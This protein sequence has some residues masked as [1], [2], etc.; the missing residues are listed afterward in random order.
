MSYISD[1]EHQARL[2]RLSEKCREIDNTDPETPSAAAGESMQKEYEAAREVGYA[3]RLLVQATLPHSKPGPGV[4][5]FERC[6]GLVTLKITADSAYGLP[7]GTYPRLILAWITSEAVRRKSAELELGDSLRQFMVK[8]GLECSGGDQGTAPRLREHMRRLFTS[9]VSATVR[10]D[11]EWHNLGFRPVERISMFWDPKRP[12]QTTIWRSCIRLNHTFYEEITRQPV[13]VDMRALQGLGLGKN[14]SPMALD[15][16][17]WLTHRFSYLKER[18][19]VPW[20]ALQLQFGG[21]YGRLRNFRAKFLKH[22]KTVLE[23]YP[24][25]D[26]EPTPRGLLLTPSKTHVPMR[27]IRGGSK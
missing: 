16:Y 10:R 3:S 2:L 15:I 12:E 14:G 20:E 17:Q 8:L 5:E 9:T 1:A 24:Q 26:V 19:T 13:P 23:F 18:I 6:N 7:Y 11:G 27:L 25:A 22:L 21:D 4:H